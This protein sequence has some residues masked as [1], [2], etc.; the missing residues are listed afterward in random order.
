MAFA[1]SPRNTRL[2]AVIT[3][4]LLVGC[5]DSDSSDSPYARA[6][7]GRWIGSLSPEWACGW[8]LSEERHILEVYGDE[9]YL[10][11]EHD[12]YVDEPLTGTFTNAPG[13]LPAFTVEPQR[14][15]CAP[16]GTCF[17]ITY[18]NIQEGRADVTVNAHQVTCTEQAVGEMHRLEP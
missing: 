8:A 2:I 7:E 15:I 17:S 6:V 13:E 11:R 16:H 18:S 9:V 4:L 3:L 1:M 10:Y 14:Q 5:G 12:G